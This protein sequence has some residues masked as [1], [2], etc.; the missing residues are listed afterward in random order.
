MHEDVDLKVSY[1]LDAWRHAV[2]VRRNAWKFALHFNGIIHIER[3]PAARRVDVT[4][5]DQVTGQVSHRP[6]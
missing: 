6:A 4:R 5:A 3:V 1:T 2:T